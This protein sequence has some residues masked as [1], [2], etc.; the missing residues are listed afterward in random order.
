[1]RWKI[2]GGMYCVTAC[3]LMSW[4]FSSLHD[5]IDWVFTAKAARSAAAGMEKNDAN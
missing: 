4:K 3:G 2:I 5:A 1:M